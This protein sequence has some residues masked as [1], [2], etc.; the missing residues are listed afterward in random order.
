[1]GLALVKGLIEAHRGVV[2]VESQIGAGTTFRVKL[3]TAAGGKGVYE[4][5]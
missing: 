1:L 4:G 3:P 2:D 5:E